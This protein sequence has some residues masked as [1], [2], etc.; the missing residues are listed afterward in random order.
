MKHAKEKCSRT[1]SH[2]CPRRLSRHVHLT[3][4]PVIRL[5]RIPHHI[6]QPRAITSTIMLQRL[7]TRHIP[8]R[9]IRRRLPINEHIPVLLSQRAVL[10][11]S[12]EG[13]RGPGAGVQDEDNGRLG[14]QLL[15]HVQEHLDA[16]GVGAEVLDLL[17]RGALV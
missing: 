8:A 4:I 10:G 17:E 2:H 7:T 6:R 13:V 14:S 5:Q 11:G 12:E 9:A 1:H 3:R 15:R 16:G